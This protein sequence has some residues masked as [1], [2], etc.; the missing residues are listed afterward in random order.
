MTVLDTQRVSLRPWQASDAAA[1]YALA[2]N[3]EIGPRAG[4]PVH[5]SEAQSL[6][7]IE[8]VFQAP[9][10]F[11]VVLKA[12]HQV[13]GSIGLTIGQASSLNL[14]DQAGEIGYWI[15]Q[16]Y[17][18]Q[19]LIPE[20]VTAVIDYALNDIGLQALWCAYY[21]GNDQSRRVQE[22]CGFRYHHTIDKD[23]VPLLNEVRQ[24][25]I[26]RYEIE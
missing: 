22:K 25:H 1:L 7:I 19:G 8:T 2:S 26:M 5:E 14:P 17:W 9:H 15:G 23:P 6:A 21:D 4:W 12:S 16:E 24:T 11:A 20:A 10:V 13:V 18:G 3:P